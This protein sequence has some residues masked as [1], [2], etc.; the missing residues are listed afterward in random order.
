MR[1]EESVPEPVKYTCNHCGEQHEADLISP[2]ELVLSV[3][4]RVNGVTQVAATVPPYVRIA[5]L[6]GLARYI[7]KEHDL[8]PES[9]YKRFM[10]EAAH[11]PM[12]KFSDN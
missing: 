6:V 2:D 4:T 11:G 12:G 1:Y 3:I 10:V 9:A 8:D 5:L 7:G